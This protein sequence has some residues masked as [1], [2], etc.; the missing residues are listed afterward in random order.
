MLSRLMNSSILLFT[1]AFSIA[2]VPLWPFYILAWE[3]RG[4]PYCAKRCVN[5]T[6]LTMPIIVQICMHNNASLFVCLYLH[7]LVYLFVWIN[8]QCFWSLC[9]WMNT[10]CWLHI[11]ERP[12]HTPF[13]WLLGLG[14]TAA[15]HCNSGRERTALCLFKCKPPFSRKK[16]EMCVWA[17]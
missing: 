5:E 3:N 11:D 17:L 9:V 2:F 12:F 16:R 13:P 15:W 7:M 1:Q 10:D 8:L 4:S 14:G 6:D